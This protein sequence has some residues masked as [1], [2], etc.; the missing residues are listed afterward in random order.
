MQR[1]VVPSLMAICAIVLSGCTTVQMPE[2]AVG[3]PAHP[4]AQAGEIPVMPT[5]LAKPETPVI[6]PDLPITGVPRSS[7]PAP[8]HVHAAPPPPPRPAAA[9]GQYVCPMHPE[10]TSPVPGTCPKCGMDLEWEDAS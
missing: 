6:A 1:H 4:D 3:H 10:V 2:V 8:A 5:V 7:P 9:E